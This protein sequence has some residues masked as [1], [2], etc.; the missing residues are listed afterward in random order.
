MTVLVF[1]RL[2]SKRII[3]KHISFVETAKDQDENFHKC[4]ELQWR[5]QY[6]REVLYSLSGYWQPFLEILQRAQDKYDLVGDTFMSQ[7]N[8]NADEDR[9]RPVGA[10]SKLT[11]RT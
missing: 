3:A 5:D 4:A 7:V 11:S 2:I 1:G 10:L 6:H 8:T 9:A